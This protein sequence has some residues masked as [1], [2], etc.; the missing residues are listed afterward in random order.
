MRSVGDPG[1]SPGFLVTELEGQGIHDRPQLLEVACGGQRSDDTGPVT[2]PGQRHGGGLHPMVRSHLCYDVNDVVTLG[3]L[4]VR[5][6]AGTITVDHL[7]PTVLTREEACSQGEVGHHPHT[8]L[9]RDLSST[10]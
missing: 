3:L 10:T 2:Q 6:H 9:G 5:N 8:E 4:V 7:A 1:E